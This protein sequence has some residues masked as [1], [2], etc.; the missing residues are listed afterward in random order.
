[1]Q[2]LIKYYFQCRA[3]NAWDGEINLQFQDSSNSGP[4]PSKSHGSV[5][6]DSASSSEKMKRSYNKTPAN[7]NK[8]SR[9]AMLCLSRGSRRAARKERATSKTE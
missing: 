2:S 5:L 1:M 6:N 8:M 7:P 9:L 3:A 4:S